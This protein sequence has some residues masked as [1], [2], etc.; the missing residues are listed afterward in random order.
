MRE[1]SLLKKEMQ[2]SLLYSLLKEIK[3]KATSEK[4]CLKAEPPKKSSTKKIRRNKEYFK[5]KT[6]E[7][8]KKHKKDYNHKVSFRTK[9][10]DISKFHVDLFSLR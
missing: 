5:S 7:K 8:K 6:K 2:E 4:Q 9:K 1:R 3:E 10:I